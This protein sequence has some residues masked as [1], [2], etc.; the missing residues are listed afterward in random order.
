[1]GGDF[2]GSITDDTLNDGK[3]LQ[4]STFYGGNYVIAK[5][6]ITRKKAADESLRLETWKK[7]KIDSLVFWESNKD[8]W[9][10][11]VYKVLLDEKFDLIADVISE[12]EENVKVEKCSNTVTVTYEDSRQEVRENNNKFLQFFIRFPQGLKK[13]EYPICFISKNGAKI[14]K[15]IQVVSVDDVW[16]FFVLDQNG[17]KNLILRRKTVSL[18]YLGILVFYFIEL[19]TTIPLK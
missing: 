4:P 13:G 17:K 12:D 10:S 18:L 15:N 1:M 6:K 2:G 16:E 7:E 3:I 14:K 19:T 9:E 5:L 11:S 8:T